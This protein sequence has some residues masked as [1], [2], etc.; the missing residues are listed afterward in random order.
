MRKSFWLS[1]TLALGAFLL[2]PMPGLS[3]SLSNRIQNQRNKVA[4]K[5]HHE[6]VLTTTISTFNNRIRGL[7]GEYPQPPDAARSGSRP[8]LDR[9]RAELAAVQNKLQ[10]AR[11]RLARLRARLAL[12]MKQLAARLVDEYESDQPDMVTVILESHGF[13]DLLTKADFMQRI[14]RQDQQVVGVVKVLKAQTAK[15]AK[16][17][18]RARAEGAGRGKRDRSPSATRWRP[19]RAGS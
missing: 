16:E 9:K 1:I 3:E 13:D 15:Q 14:S 2:L 11:D 10:V 12:A 4:S 17:L 7:Q 6:G 8:T 18:A 19:P 5:L